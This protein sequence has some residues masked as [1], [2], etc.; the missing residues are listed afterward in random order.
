M[1]LALPS[2]VVALLDDDQAKVDLGGV[3]KAISLAL[4]EDVAVGDYVIVHVGYA[5]TKVDPAEAEKTLALFAQMEAA[6]T[7]A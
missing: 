4:V 6:G 2:R 5:L 3:T 1:C 7:S